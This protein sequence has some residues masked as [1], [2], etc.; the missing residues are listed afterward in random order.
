MLQVALAGYS[1]TDNFQQGDL[2]LSFILK[3]KFHH[4]V[5]FKIKSF[6]VNQSLFK[7]RSEALRTGSKPAKE[8]GQTAE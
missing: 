1:M 7:V 3:V 8:G 6:Q 2:K 4:C 5:P